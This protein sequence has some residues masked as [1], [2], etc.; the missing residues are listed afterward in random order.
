[1]KHKHKV[2]QISSTA[3]LNRRA[4]AVSLQLQ[5]DLCAKIAELKKIVEH[6][7]KLIEKSHRLLDEAQRGLNL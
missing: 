2:L 6:S 4:R 1:M 3:G 5:D 7:Q